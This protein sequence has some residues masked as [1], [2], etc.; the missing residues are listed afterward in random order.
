MKPDS[1]WFRLN[2]RPGSIDHGE[3]GAAA[4]MSLDFPRALNPAIPFIVYS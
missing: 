2:T 4:T 1:P 3:E